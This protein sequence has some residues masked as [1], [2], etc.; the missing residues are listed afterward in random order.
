MAKKIYGIDPCKAINAKDVRDAVIK[1]FFEAHKK[2]LDE[3]EKMGDAESKEDLEKIK[4]A[5]TELMIKKYFEE[6]GGDFN[7]PTKKTIIAVCDKLA[8]FAS[9]FRPPEEIKKHY[10]EIMILIDKLEK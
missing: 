7:N 2:I 8:E 4:K 3:L 10:Q 6:V 1:C 9:N 5:D